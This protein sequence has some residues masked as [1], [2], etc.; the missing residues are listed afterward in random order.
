MKLDPEQL[1]TPPQKNVLYLAINSI[2]ALSDRQGW[3]AHAY[4]ICP[5]LY[6]ISLNN[7]IEGGGY[8]HFKAASGLTSRDIAHYGAKTIGSLVQQAFKDIINTK[9]S[10]NSCAVYRKF[11]TINSKL[12]LNQNTYIQPFN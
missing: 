8:N 4:G 2:S 1:Y 5:N 9:N 11:T 7:Y 12:A 6:C 10:R 3:Y